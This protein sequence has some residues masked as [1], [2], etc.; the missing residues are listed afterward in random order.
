MSSFLG[1]DFITPLTIY[2]EETVA[3]SRNLDRSRSIVTLPG[4]NWRFS[5]P[6][7][8]TLDGAGKL[9]AHKTKYFGRGSFNIN[10]PQFPGIVVPVTAVTAGAA[11][12]AS[13]QSFTFRLAAAGEIQAGTFFNV[14]GQP[15]L[16]QVLEDG[17]R[18][19]AG[20][21][22]LDIKPALRTA[23]AANTAISFDTSARVRYNPEGSRALTVIRGVIVRQ[24]LDLEE[25]TR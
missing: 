25:V 18:N 11:L 4:A 9:S 6:L 13:A 16:Y 14:R 12:S 7:Q 2:L 21:L 24:T 23:V 19:S 8:M 5:I 15:D 1:L 10:I 17:S 22:N 20:T 3:A